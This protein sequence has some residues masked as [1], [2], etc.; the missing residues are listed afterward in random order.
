M[1]T[2][3]RVAGIAAFGVTVFGNA[4]AEDLDRLEH[5]RSLACDNPMAPG[6]QLPDESPEL[7]A[8]TATSSW[9]ADI[10]TSS[11]TAAQA[12]RSRRTHTTCR[13]RG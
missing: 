3:F 6:P 1:R 7:G 9:A 13:G 4:V 11:S 8:S 12:R 2:V 10:T 5:S